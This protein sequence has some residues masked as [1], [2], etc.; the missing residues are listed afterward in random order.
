MPKSIA[1]E[2]NLRITSELYTHQISL[3]L[4]LPKI[5]YIIC[6]SFSSLF[7][8]RRR[9]LIIFL[10]THNSK[11]NTHIYKLSM[12]YQIDTF[13]N[14]KN[15]NISKTESSLCGKKSYF[16]IN[17][18]CKNVRFHYSYNFFFLFKN[19]SAYFF[20]LSEK[21]SLFSTTKHSVILS[22]F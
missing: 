14:S 8:K 15:R 10:T 13:P 9:T 20:P 22:I 21:V 4:S 6:L 16:I 12:E 5:S 17:K 1:K 2:V 11:H 7:L 18:C 19:L 3:N